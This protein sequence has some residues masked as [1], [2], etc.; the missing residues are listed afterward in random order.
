M[1]LP[2]VLW[3]PFILQ[4]PSFYAKIPARRS[5]KRNADRTTPLS[6]YRQNY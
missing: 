5:V 2:P 4:N 3:L 6:E 1:A